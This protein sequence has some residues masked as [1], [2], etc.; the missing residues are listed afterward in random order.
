[1]IKSL[2]EE[3]DA[4]ADK[5]K[6]VKTKNDIRKNLGQVKGNIMIMKKEYNK[7]LQ[8]SK[9]KGMF[10]SKNLS[11]TELGEQSRKILGLEQQHSK[12]VGKY[13][14][15]TLRGGKSSS[16]STDVGISFD[17]FIGSS[18]H[19]AV[20]MTGFGGKRNGNGF[21]SDAP[22]GGFG[23]G[24]GGAGF[25]G[26]GGGDRGGGGNGGD[27]SAEDGFGDED[28][29]E[30]DK[31][32]LATIKDLQE[33]IDSDLDLIG[34]G[35]AFLKE[36]AETMGEH[37][38]LQAEMLD[39]VGGEIT[40]AQTDLDSLNHKTKDTLKQQASVSRTMNIRATHHCTPQP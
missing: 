33:D 18:D 22:G 36:A 13:E 28:L 3:E 23:G 26:G 15:K 5:I 32:C 34:Q 24:G 27:F 4:D 21:S 17:A 38:D 20:E 14:D 6:L 37:I 16:S 39:E 25:G 30:F 12:L 7:Q 19:T 40:K 9:K 11:D 8:K 10:K 29:T 31:Q 2:D 35:I 1:M